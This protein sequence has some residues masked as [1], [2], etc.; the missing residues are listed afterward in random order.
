MLQK[1]L[2]A[3]DGSEDSM[4][5][6]D[7]ALQLAKINN[8]QIEI[9]YVRESV[10]SYSSRVV[11]DAVEMEKELIE[12]A[13]EIIAKG[14]AKFQDA[15]VM[16][17]TKIITGD[18]ADAICEE[19]EHNGITE[20]VIGSRGISGVSRFFLGSVSLK[21]LTHAHCTAIIVR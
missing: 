15:D 16:Y 6:A 7:Y 14:A 2:L 19:A 12:D 3:F 1:I 9:V 13:E 4:K 17:T 10:T 5:A 8:A 11:Y 21:V 20:I 18:P